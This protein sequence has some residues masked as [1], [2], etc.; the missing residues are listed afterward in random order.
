[1]SK[2][3]EELEHCP[4]SVL[5]AWQVSLIQLILD[6]EKECNYSIL[7]ENVLKTTDILL[8]IYYS[9][10]NLYKDNFHAIV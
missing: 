3:Q 4:A 10:P 8:V 1:M 2:R 7:N 5:T 9:Y 6:L